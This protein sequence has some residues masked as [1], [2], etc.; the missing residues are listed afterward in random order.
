MNY[1]MTLIFHKASLTNSAV[2]KATVHRSA[3]GWNDPQRPFPIGGFT[4]FSGIAPRIAV[5]GSACGFVNSAVILLN[6]HFDPLK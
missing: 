1:S 2:H 3:G 4:A 6:S 5:N